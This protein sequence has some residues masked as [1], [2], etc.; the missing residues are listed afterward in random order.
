MHLD[1]IVKV[2]RLD[3]LDRQILKKFFYWI[4]VYQTNSYVAFF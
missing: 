4:F 1:L 2:K 3:R